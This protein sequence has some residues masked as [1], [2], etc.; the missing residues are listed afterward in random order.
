[1]PDI[2]RQHKQ[3]LHNAIQAFKDHNPQTSLRLLA[4]FIY[5]TLQNISD[6]H[7]H[8]ETTSEYTETASEHTSLSNSEDELDLNPKQRGKDRYDRLRQEKDLRHGTKKTI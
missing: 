8:T 2:V 4:A 6:F 5:R 3:M 1:M 7:E